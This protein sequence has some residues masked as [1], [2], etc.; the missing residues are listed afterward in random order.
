MTVT[1]GAAQD[2]LRS[3]GSIS[4]DTLDRAVAQGVLTVQQVDLLHSLERTGAPASAAETQDDESFRFIGG[5]S[6]IFV[7][8]GLVLFLG[9]LSYF[10]S[11]AAGGAGTSFAV[12]LASWL[13]AEYFTRRRRMALPSIV[14]L[15]IFAG[16]TFITVADLYPDSRNDAFFFQRY[17]DAGWPAFVAGLATAAATAV[18]YW[19]FRVPITIAAGAA[20][21]AAAIVGLFFALEPDLAATATMPLVLLCGLATFALAMRFDLSDPGRQTRRTDIAFWLHM[22]AA[23]LIVHPLLK[24]LT[25]DGDMDTASALSILAIFMVLAFVALVVDR[26]AI[27]VSGL[28]YAGYAFGSLIVKAG[29]SDGVVPLTMLVLGALVLLLSAGWHALRRA[30]L[31]L[32]PAALVRRLAPHT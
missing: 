29:L 24:G 20:A 8:I 1:S 31:G 13:L 5:F 18:H 30:L 25:G 6:D 12:A 22:L 14:L 4:A 21:L 17:L 3:A 32:L 15:L 11:G 27:L 19:R 7:T 10:S 2:G 23:P 16:S 28:A 26:R 9:A